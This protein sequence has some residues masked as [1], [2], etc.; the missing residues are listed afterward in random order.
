MPDKIKDINPSIK[1]NILAFLSS[2]ENVPKK[3][4]IPENIPK[5]INPFL[6]FILLKNK[7]IKAKKYSF[8]IIH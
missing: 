5:R 2:I 7:L 8:I 4:R 3:K 1:K 6:L